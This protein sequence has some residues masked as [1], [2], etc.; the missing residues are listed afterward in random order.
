VAREIEGGL[1]Q[2]RAIKG[3][4]ENAKHELVLTKKGAAK[5]KRGENGVTQKTKNIGGGNE[6]V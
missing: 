5:V 6:G 3:A 4:A 2:K 1:Y